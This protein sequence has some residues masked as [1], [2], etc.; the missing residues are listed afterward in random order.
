MKTELSYESNTCRIV[1][2]LKQIF[3]TEIFCLIYPTINETHKNKSTH[4]ITAIFV[5]YVQGNSLEKSVLFTSFLCFRA[6]EN[7][8]LSR[9]FFKIWH[10]YS[11]V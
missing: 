9:F 1:T 6:F 5:I 10:I 11:H 8:I 3:T 4:A 7:D 2:E